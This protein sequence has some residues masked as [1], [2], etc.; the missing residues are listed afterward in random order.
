MRGSSSQ[1]WKEDDL[2]QGKSGRQV[3]LICMVNVVEGLENMDDVQNIFRSTDEWNN[4]CM[5]Y[6]LY[7]LNT[8]KEWGWVYI[9]TDKMSHKNQ[10]KRQPLLFQ[11]FLYLGFKNNAI[12]LF[13]K[14][15]EN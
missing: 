11:C 6:L 13:I 7:M 15:T 14:K 1:A 9:N 10:I 2:N 4:N 5:S 8:I 12:A 3:C